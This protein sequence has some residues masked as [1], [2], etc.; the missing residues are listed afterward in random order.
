LFTHCAIIVNIFGK[1]S[2]L[3]RAQLGLRF[4]ISFAL[5]YLVGMQEI[6]VSASPFTAW[7][8][9]FIMYQLS[10]GLSDAIP[11][12][13]LC[14]MITYFTFNINSIK[15]YKHKL[16]NSIIAIF[17]IAVVF[18]VVRITGYKIGMI[19]SDFSVYSIQVFVWTLLFG[20]TLGF[21]YIYLRP[22]YSKMNFQTLKLSVITIGMNWIIFNSFI[23]LIFKGLMPQM[24]LRSIIDTI[25]LFITSLLVGKIIKEFAVIN[26]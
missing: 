8:I 24:L 9:D 12:F 23:G 2:L 5:I 3:S 22:I 25:S 4:G 18:T 15:I 21:I 11:V 14:M 7:G 20:I 13:L 6:V 19:E 17:I 16:L 1:K 10:M 26:E